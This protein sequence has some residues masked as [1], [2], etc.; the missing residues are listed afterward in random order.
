MGGRGGRPGAPRRSGRGTWA[1][2]VLL[3]GPRERA[4]PPRALPPRR[5]SCPFGRGASS[6]GSRRWWPPRPRFGEEEV[7]AATTARD[8]LS[9]GPRDGGG[10]RR[11]EPARPPRPPRRVA[12]SHAVVFLELLAWDPARAAETL[13]WADERLS[14]GRGTPRASK[15][16][17]PRTRR[18]RSLR[19]CCGVW[20]SGGGSAPSTSPS[21]PTS[22]ASWR[23]GTGP[24][25]RSSPDGV[26]GTCASTRRG[27]ARCATPRASG[28]C[29]RAS[30]PRTGAG[31]RRRPGDPGSARASHVVLCPREQPQ[32]RRG[33][34]GRAGP[35]GAGV[36][37]CLGTDSLASAETLDVLDDAALLRAAVSRRSHPADLVRM[38]TAGGAEALGLDDL[39]TPGAGP[40]CGA[41]LR[42]HGRACRRSLR[43]PR[44]GRGPSPAEWSSA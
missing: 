27:R 33:D 20:S 21:R 28:S 18:T 26:S 8:R 11:L 34:G 29:S 9:R 38:A 16:A 13:A 7:R 36:R 12:S 43:A 41:G 10:G 2:G 35:P 5:A 32:P 4:L 3:P 44:L 31:G 39:G 15:C 40:A 23:R 30:W 25:R 6:P 42:P 37:L 17:W 24:G 19:S 22:R 14:H 1:R